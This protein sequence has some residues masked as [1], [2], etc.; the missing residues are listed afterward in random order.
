MTSYGADFLRHSSNSMV[1]LPLFFGRDP[2][3][4]VK[5]VRHPHDWFTEGRFGLFIHFGLY[6]LLGRHE[7]VMTNERT[8]PQEYERLAELFDPDRFDAPALARAARRA[9]MRYAVLTAKHHEGFALYGTELSDYNSVTACGRDLVREFVEAFRAEGLRVGLYYSLLDWHHPDF[10]IDYHHPLRDLPDARE[11]NDVRDMAQYRQYLH[12]QVRELLTHYG[13]VDYLFYDFTYV[14]PR[15]GWDGK[16]P[17]AWDS[18]GLLD[19]TREL[20]PGIIVNDRL[21]I[22]A[23]VVTPEQYQPD[24]PMTRD[25]AEVPWEACQTL[26]GSWGY[27]RENLGYKSPDLLIRMLADTVSKNGNLLLNVGPDGRGG[28]APRDTAS[29]EAIGDW[30]T[31]HERAV[32]GA[33][34]AGLAAPSGTV[35]TRN[36][37]RLYLHLFT[38]P[39]GHVHLRGLAGKVRFA[40]LLDDGAEI[41]TSEISP[42][43]QAWNTELGGQPAGTLTL[44]LP[45]VR[46]EVAVPVIELFLEPEGS[47]DNHAEPSTEVRTS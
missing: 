11:R 32:I 43:Q 26:N 14:E 47:T 27:D 33:G 40:R 22:P 20:Q 44:H 23:D 35:L 17:D 37:D 46:P 30:M 2:T 6:S 10:T 24:E 29:L 39:F 9:G 36:G 25:G 45:T 4:S 38:W 34:A 7:W 3:S 41:R 31:L 21:W 19:L 28:I 8:S 1:T 15:D 12:G 18:A 42:D 16:G 5:R 13:T